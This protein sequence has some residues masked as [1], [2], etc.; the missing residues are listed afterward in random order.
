MPAR[1]GAGLGAGLG[2][3]GAD[4]LLGIHFCSGMSRATYQTALRE[5]RGLQRVR[6][7]ELHVRSDNGVSQ[8]Q[9]QGALYQS[10]P[11][12]LRTSSKISPS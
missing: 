10:V 8:L 2:T 6:T 12:F 3:V 5:F 9:Q 11:S 7:K 1:L 4:S